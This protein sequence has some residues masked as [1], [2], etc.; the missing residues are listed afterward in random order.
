MYITP[1]FCIKSFKIGNF[2]LKNS[3]KLST[4]TRNMIKKTNSAALTIPKFSEIKLLK[5]VGNLQNYS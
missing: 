3:L 1:Y 2:S 4:T 5:T